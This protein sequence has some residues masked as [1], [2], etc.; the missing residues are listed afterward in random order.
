MD[1]LSRAIP[2]T[3]L[4]FVV[5]SMLGVGLA[6]TV[7]HI[8]APLRNLRV[9]S[10]TLVG[11]VVLM[12][13]GALAIARGLRLDEPLGVALLLLL[14]VT[15]ARGHRSCRCSLASAKAI[16]PTPLV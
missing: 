1:V 4:V 5:S 6:L 3:V 14:L 8:L 11:N 13:L 15:A 10:L 16:S 7:N 2:V 9:V 12:P